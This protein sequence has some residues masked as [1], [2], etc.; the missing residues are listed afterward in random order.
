MP[1]STYNTNNIA[2]LI[3]IMNS[4]DH[5]SKITFERITPVTWK[6]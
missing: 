1:A 3:L 4:T 5:N 6:Y 2:E